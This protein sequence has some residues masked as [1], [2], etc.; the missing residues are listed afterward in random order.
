[1]MPSQMRSQ[2]PASIDQFQDNMINVVYNFCSI[3][4]MPVE[5]VLRPFHG[6]RYFAPV[7]MVFSA[8][9]MILLPVIFGFAGAVSHFMPFAQAPPEAMIGMWVFTRLFFLGC[10]I[11][12]I[13]KFRLMLHMERELSSL[14]EGPALFFFGLLPGGFWRQRILYE[15]LFLFALSIVL[16]NFFILDTAAANFLM[17]SSFFLAMKE[18]T[19]WYMQWQTI[20][21]LMDMKFAGP[22]IA[23]MADNQASDDE[24]AM[25]HMASFPKD[26]PDEIRRDMV[27][28]Y[29]ARVL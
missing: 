9:M 14:Y 25:V 23:R 7:I 22:I 1:M 12:G 15:P 18:Y 10:L 5:M 19:A 8:A 20:R 27:E 4:T 2:Q 6:T 11:H 3:V 29:K 28:A 21:E 13:R 26:T 17:F 16:P 24:L